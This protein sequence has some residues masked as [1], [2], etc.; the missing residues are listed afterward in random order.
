MLASIGILEVLVKELFRPRP[1][2]VL[3]HTGAL[4]TK[5]VRNAVWQSSLP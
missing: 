3:P 4:L 1:I 5:S 2:L